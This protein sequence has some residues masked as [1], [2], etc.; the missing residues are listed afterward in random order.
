MT[1]SY[2]R[3]EF[4]GDA[5]LDYLLTVHLY[6]NFPYFNLRRRT[7]LRSALVSRNTF[8]KLAISLQLHKAFLHSSPPLYELIQQYCENASIMASDLAPFENKVLVY[9]I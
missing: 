8:A 4:L 1:D 2:E 5:V 6:T 7:D 9:S 3:L